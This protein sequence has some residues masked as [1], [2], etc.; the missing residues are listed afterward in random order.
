MIKKDSE[1]FIFANG[2]TQEF[3]N[4]TNDESATVVLKY[5]H[6]SIESLTSLKTRKINEIRASCGIAINEGFEVDALGLGYNVHYRTN[7]ND[8]KRIIHAKE[9]VAGGLIWH[10][11]VLQSHTQS[12]AKA[13]YDGYMSHNDAC[14]IRYSDLFT[15]I[16]NASEDDREWLDSLT[17]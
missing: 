7:D 12:Q 16:K 1:I 8:Q 10:G 2:G 6:D 15:Q 11:E 17:W 5:H 4:R 3:P 9:S 13:V 14:S